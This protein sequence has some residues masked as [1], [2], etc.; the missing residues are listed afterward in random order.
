M[1]VGDLLDAIDEIVGILDDY[2]KRDGGSFTPDLN[3]DIKELIAVLNASLESA[4]HPGAVMRGPLGCPP[5]GIAVSMTTRTE[6]VACSGGAQ[7]GN[8]T[9]PE[10]SPAPLHHEHSAGST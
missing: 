8:R 6:F 4:A 5:K 2:L 3:T 1:R 10:F 9:V 7:D